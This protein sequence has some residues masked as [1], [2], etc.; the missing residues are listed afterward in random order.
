MPFPHQAGLLCPGG[1]CLCA[2]DDDAPAVIVRNRDRLQELTATK[3][4]RE[5]AAVGAQYQRYWP[6]DAQDGGDLGRMF[7]A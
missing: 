6:H 7:E 5:T 2:C 1:P 4:V 3:H